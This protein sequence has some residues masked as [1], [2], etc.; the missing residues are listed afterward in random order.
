[1]EKTQLNHTE[2]TCHILDAIAM[3]LRQFI[4]HAVSLYG[5]DADYSLVKPI[6]QY[7]LTWITQAPFVDFE[8]EI[9]NFKGNLL[10]LSNVFEVAH[11]I[12]FADLFVREV[13]EQMKE[14]ILGRIG[15]YLN[16]QEEERQQ[17]YNAEYEKGVA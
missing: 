11:G 3:P 2:V 4:D 1:M 9:D 14:M 7:P 6:Q 16:K 8:F 17:V 13:G 15:Y 10:S 5:E 12:L